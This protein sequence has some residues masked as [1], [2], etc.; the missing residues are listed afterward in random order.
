MRDRV[1]ESER[2][3]RDMIQ[4]DQPAS[5]P[6]NH[7]HRHNKR[8]SE[9]SPARVKGQQPAPAVKMSRKNY[10]SK[11]RR[12]KQTNSQHSL[13]SFAVKTKANEDLF[14]APS[15]RIGGCWSTNIIERV[16]LLSDARIIRRISRM[17]LACCFIKN[18]PMSMNLP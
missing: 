10:F 12:G 17:H 2:D 11:K 13:C 3:R 8:P 14:L 6:H 4:R 9:S 5:Q 7:N 16:V 15:P 18:Q 1:R